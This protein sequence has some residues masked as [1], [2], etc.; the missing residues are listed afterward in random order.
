MTRR[1]AKC[2]LCAL[3]AA[4]IYDM[5]RHWRASKTEACE[6]LMTWEAEGGALPARE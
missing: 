4:V 5:R 3:A 2:V 6:A 1:F